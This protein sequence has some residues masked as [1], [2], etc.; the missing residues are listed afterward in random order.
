MSVWLTIKP[1]PT[2]SQEPPLELLLFLDP[3]ANQGSYISFSCQN[4]VL[5]PCTCLGLLWYSSCLSVLFNYFKYF[6]G[7]TYHIAN[8]NGLKAYRWM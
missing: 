3:G 5:L 7:T 1:G 8:V 6:L 4:I 2:M